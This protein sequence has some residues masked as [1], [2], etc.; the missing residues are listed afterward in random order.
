MKEIFS[1]TDVTQ[2]SVFE[3]SLLQGDYS[4]LISLAGP[5]EVSP[6]DIKDYLING[7]IQVYSVT[8]T[9]NVLQVNYHKPAWDEGIGQWQLIIPL[10][11]PLV[12]VGAVVFG[13]FKI[14]DITKALVPLILVLGGVIVLVL[15]VGKEPITA[16]A[17]SRF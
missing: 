1:T 11:V 9:G 3:Q 8:L 16:L 10:L 13:I 2:A 15:A 14:E 17:K 7:G 6:D 12:V 5:L 4:I